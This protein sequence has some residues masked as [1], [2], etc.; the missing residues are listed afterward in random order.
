MIARY[1]VVQEADKRLIVMRPY[2]VYGAEKMVS[3]AVETGNN[4][5]IWHTTGSGKTLTS[6]KVSQLIAEHGKFKKVFFLVDRRDLNDQTVSEFEKY[7]AGSISD[8][9]T[10]RELV[11]NIASTHRDKRLILT[12]MQKVCQGIKNDQYKATMDFEREKAF[13]VDECHRTQFGEM[14]DRIRSHFPNAQHFGFTGTP[15]FSAN[16]SGAM[17]KI[18]SSAFGECLHTYL[19]K[20]GIADNNTLPFSME[21]VSTFNV[22]DEIVDPDW[23]VKG[24]L[25]RELWHHEDRIKNIVD[26]II[27]DRRRKSRMRKFNAMLTVDSVH[28]VTL[29]M[30]AFKTAMSGIEESARLR[31][32]TVY[33]TDENTSSEDGQVRPHKALKH[34]IDEYNATFGCNFDIT[35][36]SRYNSDVTTRFKAGKI[37]I[38][39][40]V[41]MMLT[42]F[43][44]RNLNTLYVDRNLENHGLIQAYSR[45][46]RVAG[47]SKQVGHV[48]CFRN[49]KDKTDEAVRLFSN[50]EN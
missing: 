36:V 32:A 7:Q 50:V 46:N 1:M 38:L 42:G 18:T 33:S 19:L 4:G 10:T 48:R 11:K 37:D 47:A 3:C 45:T 13:V 17:G 31:V 44:S 23:E 8:S 2:Q 34:Y 25:T 24:I 29:Y 39:V 9:K 15:I 43:D 16:R 6:F 40:V 26:D 5:F 14:Q 20:D 30:K 41:N 22:K 21:Y 28:A 27:V 49:L 35:D 12:T